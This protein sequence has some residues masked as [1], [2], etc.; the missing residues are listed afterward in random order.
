MKLQLVDIKSLP[1]T[2][3]I[4]GTPLYTNPIG[5]IRKFFLKR[6][7]LCISLLEVEEG[8]IL[9]V[10]CG[11]GILLPTLSRINGIIVGM[12][13]HNYLQRV[14][15]Y[16]KKND[17][18]N[19]WLVR[20]DS[21]FLPFRKSVFSAI[22]MISLL[23]HLDKPRL[24]INELSQT[25]NSKATIIFGFHI[26]NVFYTVT[27]FV[28][29][30]LYV[31]FY[32]IKFKKLKEAIINLLKSNTWRHL[33]SDSILIQWI[34]EKLHIKKQIYLRVGRPIYLAIKSV[35]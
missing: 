17:F 25:T 9:D 23:D 6:I 14:D 31:A 33:Y 13:V 32:V 35:K 4:D 34:M 19:I 5:L 21:H 1:K 20:A 28:W 24:A 29:T 30:I 27:I 15:K 22:L 7:E 18:Q 10:G 16:L 11:S 2:S 26:N 8:N 3:V 12:D